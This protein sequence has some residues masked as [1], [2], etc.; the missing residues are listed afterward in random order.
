M[1][2]LSK[3]EQFARDISKLIIYCTN[4]GYGVTKDWAYRPQ[5][6][7]DSYI[8]EGKSKAKISYHTKRQAEDINIWDAD[9]GAN[10]ISDEEWIMMGEYWESLSKYNKWGGRYSVPKKKYKTTVGWDRRHFERSDNR[11]KP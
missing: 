4:M 5:W 6:V 3:R 10:P 8:V 9:T 2:N 11:R 1:R 7:Q